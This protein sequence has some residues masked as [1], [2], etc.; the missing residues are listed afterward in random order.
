MLTLEKSLATA[1][2]GQDVYKLLMQLDGEVYRE[3][4]GRRTFRFAVA[5]KSYFAKVFMGVGWKTLLACLFKF[6][7]PI[8]SAENEK[9]AIENL[10]RI[11]IA[12]MQLAGYGR[13]GVNP[14]R[15]QSFLITE[16][17][18]PTISLEDYCRD[19]NVN[20]P[21]P[22]WKRALIQSVAQ[23]ARTLHANGIMHRDFYLCHFL[24]DTT[25][26]PGQ[27]NS[28]E[29]QLYLIDLHRAEQHRH[30]KERWRI[31]DVA[32]LYFSSMDIGLT[33]RDLLRFIEEYRQCHWREAL[34]KETKFW[35][36]VKRRGHAG[37]REF[38]R[39]N[40]E[41]FRESAR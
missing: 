24:L 41:L 15:I 32:G 40:P 29:P 20:P 33:K 6:R 28:G 7:K 25:P 12:T 9:K 16:E 19:W 13:R 35:E 4:E 14:A 39:K 5:D 18:K 1:W 26:S 22:R 27:F 3:K 34:R 30:L 10:T 36:K 8:V 21:S 31:K 11:G 23:I 2:Q 37:Y 17:L 38:K